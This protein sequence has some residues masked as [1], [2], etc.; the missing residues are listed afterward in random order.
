[1]CQASSSPHRRLRDYVHPWDRVHPF[2]S[3]APLSV[4]QSDLQH[5]E[6]AQAQHSTHAQATMDMG[7][8]TGMAAEV[9]HQ[10]SQPAVASPETMP[11]PGLALDAAPVPAVRQG[12]RMKT[13]VRVSGSAE[14]QEQ[15]PAVRV[16]ASRRVI[17]ITESPRA[18]S[19]S[20]GA[21]S[22]SPTSSPQSP[23]AAGI[24]PQGDA[25][26]PDATISD[27]TM[28]AGQQR[29]PS[30]DV[31]SSHRAS[32]QLQSASNE[33][34]CTERL[35][36]ESPPSDAPMRPSS[37]IAYSFRPLHD[38]VPQSNQSGHGCQAGTSGTS[39]A[40]AQLSQQAFALPHDTEDTGMLDG[41]AA[42]H[43]LPGNAEPSAADI[44]AAL[45]G[46]SLMSAQTFAGRRKHERKRKQT[47]VQRVD[48][49]LGQR[50]RS[51][52]ADLAQ[53]APVANAAAAGQSSEAVQEAV[54]AVADLAGAALAEAA[55]DWIPD[56]EAMQAASA[57]ARM[58][59]SE[60][61][62]D[63]AS[64]NILSSHQ[65]MSQGK[66][67]TLPQSKRTQRQCMY[68]W[69]AG[70]LIHVIARAFE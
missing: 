18:K 65:S 45:H 48:D 64:A 50:S 69:I 46:F 21:N 25:A 43:Q 30:P 60:W 32:A 22:P 39:G 20:P 12:P 26:S 70:I 14:A 53:Q 7:S 66:R 41:V 1:M 27:T 2:F 24:G 13:T 61:T 31:T 51:I 8:P 63:S 56:D 15:Q 28:T 19:P 4:S 44:F 52:S 35:W 38:A 54:L 40:L 55:E 10:D 42:Q 57:L 58:A 37:D 16:V 29:S 17:I 3:Q 59:E 47:P 49:Q 9:M 5:A 67:H 23:R 68:C 62:G 11:E 36:T 6:E 34:D 33:L